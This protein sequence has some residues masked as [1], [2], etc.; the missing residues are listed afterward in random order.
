[1][2]TKQSL[3]LYGPYPYQR[4]RSFKY[5]R[6]YV[7]D[8]QTFIPSTVLVLKASTWGA[9]KISEVFVKDQSKWAVAAVCR[10]W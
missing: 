3:V 9:L 5:D 7:C 2:M 8:C 1:M 6:Y 4:F 10:H